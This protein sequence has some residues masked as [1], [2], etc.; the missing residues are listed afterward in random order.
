MRGYG[1]VGGGGGNEG[2]GEGFESVLTSVDCGPHSG[3]DGEDG[4]HAGHIRC[5][6]YIL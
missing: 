2:R 3:E 6:S 1:R 4:D 5:A